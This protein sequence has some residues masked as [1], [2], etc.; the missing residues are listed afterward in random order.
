MRSAKTWLRALL[1]G[2]QAIA[3]V[4]PFVLHY[5][6]SHTMGAHR[7]FKVRGDVYFSGIL[8]NVNLTIAAILIAVLFLSLLCLFFAAAKQR[9][10]PKKLWS[11]VSIMLVTLLLFLIL[12][13]P[14]VRAL[15]IFPW[16]L[17]CAILI[18]LIQIAKMLLL[19]RQSF[20]ALTK[21]I[22]HVPATQ[23]QRHE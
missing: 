21:S 16:L 5:Y 7:H 8:S 13:L 3:F 1:S 6:G 23:E 20:V 15:L 17:L 9:P 18:W 14:M 19:D 12:V 11:L 22:F 2:I 4:A 10:Q